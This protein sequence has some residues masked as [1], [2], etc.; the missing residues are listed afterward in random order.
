MFYYIMIHY[1]IIIYCM[2]FCDKT[3]SYDGDILYFNAW[4]R[5]TTSCSSLCLTNDLHRICNMG[6]MESHWIKSSSPLHHKTINVS[7]AY[8]FDQCN[9]FEIMNEK[10]A[11]L[12]PL[13]VAKIQNYYKE[14]SHLKPRAQVCGEDPGCPGPVPLPLLLLPLP[15]PLSSPLPP[16]FSSDHTPGWPCQCE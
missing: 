11:S 4:K 8:T 9:P 3:S 14:R 6:S 7:L 2:V 1:T 5:G 16:D 12:L 10:F 15:S 13:S